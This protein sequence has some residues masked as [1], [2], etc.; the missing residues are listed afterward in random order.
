MRYRDAPARREAI[1]ELLGSTGYLRVGEVA[2]SLGVSEMTARRDLKRLA[3]D[4]A[5]DSVRGGIRMAAADPS[6]SEFELRR[7][8]EA[9]AKAAV[10]L[11]AAETIRPAD[12]IALDAGTTA[13]QVAEHLPSDF[14]GTVVTHSIPVI[15]L[16]SRQPQGRL[17][18]L[19]GE[20]F[21]PSKA[22]VGSMTTGNAQ[23]LRVA[24]FFLGAGGVDQRGIY[25]SADVE[26][27]V[28]QVMMDIADQ[29][30]LVIDHRKYETPAPVLL[31]D[32]NRINRVICDEEPP[33]AIA[34]ALKAAHV[35]VSVTGSALP[36]TPR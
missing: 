36:A 7:A 17:I 12:V 5:V 33:P 14:R 9:A 32:W 23:G 11:F 15:D 1:L 19:G 26:R 20:A 30:V 34:H 35:V 8:S 28:K 27:G 3:E 31:C 25:A 16:L 18:A 24:T 10:G 29:V 21:R 4:G 6:P 13:Y 2:E 22:L